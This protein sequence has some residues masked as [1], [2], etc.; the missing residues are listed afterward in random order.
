MVDFDDYSKNAVHFFSLD[1]APLLRSLLE[2]RADKF[3]L[4]DLGCGDGNLVYALKQAGLLNKAGKVVGVDLS[5][6]RLERFTAYTGFQ[7]IL[8]EGQ[9]VEQIPDD[10]I[11]LVLNSMVIEHVPDDAALLAEIKRMLRPGGQLYIT[12]VIKQPG[13]WY[14]R[15][16]PDGHWVLDPTHLREYSSREVFEQLI[17]NAGLHICASNLA[18]LRFPVLHPILRAINRVVPLRAINQ[19]FLRGGILTLL[20]RIAIPVPRYRSIEVV[21]CKDISSGP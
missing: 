14:F 6:R 11:D 17:H 16:A 3:T 7:G 4:L 19:I 13:A 12:T 5:P 8:S 20:E 9:K 15:R 10:S 21:A 18:P 2:K 1:V